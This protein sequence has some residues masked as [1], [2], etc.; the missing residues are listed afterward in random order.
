MSIPKPPTIYRKDYQPAPFLIETIDLCFRLE[1]E[2]TTVSAKTR[3]FKNPLNKSE[4]DSLI[5]NGEQLVLKSVK[6]NGKELN[7]NDY[8]VT[9]YDLE[10][11]QTGKRFET[12]ITTIIDPVNNSSLEGLYR[13]SGNYCTQCEA[14]GFRRITYSIDRPD[15]LA[16][17]TTRIEGDRESCPVLLSNGNLTDQGELPGGSH[18]A[19]WQDPYPKPCYLFALVAGDLVRLEDQFFTRSGKTINLHFYVEERN[20]E[21]C[22]HAIRSLKRAMKWDEEV[23]GL[24]YDLDCYMIVAVDDFN[25]GAME[26]KGLN[27][28]NS[29]YVLATPETATDQDYQGIEGV[30]AHEYFHNWTGN[31]VTCRDWFQLSLKEGLTVF[32]DQQ[33]SADMHSKPVKRIEDVQVLRNYQFKEDSGPMAHPVRPDSYVEINNFY[34]ATVYNKG[35]EVIRMMFTLLGYQLFRAGIDLYFKRFDGQAVTCEDF[36][37]SMEAASGRDMKQFRLWYSQA[38]TPIL[39]V[40]ELFSKSNQT[41]SLTISQIIPEKNKKK[42]QPFHI[43]I[44][45]G[46]LDAGGNDI[47]CQGEVDGQQ[48]NSHDTF[49]LKKESQTI[50]FCPIPKKPVL[51][52]LRSFSAP[53][54]VEPF[55]SRDELG[56]LMK[57]DSDSFNR[58]DSAQ[59]FAESIIMEQI[60]QLA[61]GKPPTVDDRF[62][63]G[64]RANLS[65]TILDKSL[66]ALS[67]RL[68]AETYLA[69]QME[70][71]D[72]ENLHESIRNTRRQL[73]REL[74]DELIQVYHENYEKDFQINP[75]SLGKRSLKNVCLYYLMDPDWFSEEGVELC[76]KQ[77]NH[78]S[79]MTDV[80]SAFKLIVHA[81]HPDKQHILDDFYSRYR[82][83]PLVVD[84]WFSVQ[85]TSDHPDC[86]ET[87]KQLT[88]HQSFSDKNPNR[89]RSLI[90]GFCSMNHFCFHAG[91]G[92][93]YRFLREWILHVDGFNPQIAARLVTPLIGWERYG[94]S[95]KRLMR[96]QLE[97]IIDSDKVSKDVFEIVSKSLQKD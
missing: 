20:R 30:I 51:S 67:M 92:A 58:W 59:R 70:V 39:V 41:Y 69:E 46:L 21:K 31:R 85:A 56:F 65:N 10:I 8:T 19:V 86:L 95:R 18:Y 40:Q 16:R 93:G 79:N 83:D 73:S 48:I 53:V 14:E 71:I 3:F 25:M 36:I 88:K 29:K 6:V 9:D 60:N 24:E 84:K 45:F 75:L 28:F 34:T 74:R 76:F 49:E 38:G 78:R 47:Q 61:T 77:Y 82:H 81:N 66:L 32:R 57:H 52:F 43:P 68:P 35:A 23:Y 2:K 26:N 42:C 27:I 87:V 17:Y 33:F 54:K 63:N 96:K 7:S 1:K 50:V 37:Q 94:D 90:G 91:D 12:E 15:V 44:R 11:R 64:F 89:L 80:L 55:L 13:S 72:P 62:V 22:D 4:S 97:L 5:L